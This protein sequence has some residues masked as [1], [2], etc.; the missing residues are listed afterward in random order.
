MFPKLAIALGLAATFLLISPSAQAQSREQRLETARRNYQ[1]GVAAYEAG[2]LHVAVRK[3]LA[4]QRAWRS[5][6]NAFNIAR[7]FE[8]MGEAGKGIHWFRIYLRFG[9]PD[10]AE[11]ADIER[12]IAALAVLRERQQAQSSQAGPTNDE[13]TGEA[14]RLYEEGLRFYRRRQYEVAYQVFQNACSTLSAAQGQQLGEC[15]NADI[16][17]N[18]ART[19]ERLERW[20]EARLHYRKYLRLRPNASDRA[21]VEARMRELREQARGS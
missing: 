3:L 16:S 11:R 1:Q 15:D 19:A 9:R 14:Q 4:A 2:E 5:P 20:G 12:R 21:E 7:C 13:L 17:Y 8:R 18:L 6:Q 10:G